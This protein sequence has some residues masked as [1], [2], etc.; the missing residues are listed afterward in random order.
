LSSNILI[1]LA[2]GR[3]SARIDAASSIPGGLNAL[4]NAVDIR[5]P[6]SITARSFAKFRRHAM[7]LVPYGNVASVI[8][9]VI[10]ALNYLDEIVEF[11]IG[12]TE[13]T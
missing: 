11:G 6:V 8:T 1:S 13:I 5:A 4:V 2:H 7:W 9:H 12:F 10:I 3:H